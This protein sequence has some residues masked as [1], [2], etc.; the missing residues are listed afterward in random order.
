MFSF[1]RRKPK[2]QPPQ[3]ETVQPQPKKIELSISMDS[4][5]DSLS[6]D[7]VDRWNKALDNFDPVAYE[8]R[9][10]YR[11]KILGF[12]KAKTEYV[13]RGYQITGVTKWVDTRNKKEYS[14]NSFCELE[15]C[16][17]GNKVKWYWMRTQFNGK[18]FTST[19]MHNHVHQKKT[20]EAF[21]KE[22][23]ELFRDVSFDRI[24][25]CLADDPD[26]NSE[27]YFEGQIAEYK[28][29]M[30]RIARE[31]EERER[32]IYANKGSNKK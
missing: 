21:F 18:I 2:P 28:E 9:Q 16:G 29:N 20:K 11:D 26:F 31:K 6:Q 25:G 32:N 14:I 23:H 24:K 7:E 4:I 27:D 15:L 3:Q 22:M 5:I 19:S 30:E 12:G 13:G 1:F 17:S 8:K 10:V